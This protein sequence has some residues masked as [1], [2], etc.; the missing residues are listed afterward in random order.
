MRDHGGSEWAPLQLANTVTPGIRPYAR[1]HATQEKCARR[2]GRRSRRG[3][4]KAGTAEVAD[5]SSLEDEQALCFSP[6]RRF[7]AKE[8]RER[9]PR[10]Y[11][12]LE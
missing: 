9:P 4:K 11:D 7:D 2:R 1:C 3:G 6:E 8:R 12:K 5:S 10:R